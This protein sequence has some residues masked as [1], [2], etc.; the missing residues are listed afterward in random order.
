MF[1]RSFVSM[2]IVWFAAL[3]G[4]A[5]EAPTVLTLGDSITAGGSSFSCY[6]E[7]LVPA[8]E[9][10]GV[11]FIGP[12]RD[13]I[14]AHA[15]YGGRNSAFLRDKIGE[16][17]RAHPADFVL[18]H[19]G[20]NNF[21]ESN[22]VPRVVADTVSIVETI[23]DINPGAVILLGQVIPSG[24]LPK[25][26][27]IPELNRELA[28]LAARLKGRGDGIVVVDHADGFQWERD[29]VDDKVHP[30][31][32][33]AKKMAGKW[34]DALSPLLGSLTAPA[35]TLQHVAV[36][37]HLVTDLLMAKKGVRMTNWL[38]AE[39][40]SKFVMP[41][42]NRIW[43]PAKI[44]WTLGGVRSVSTRAENRAEVIDY[45]LKSKRDSDG[46]GDPQRIRKLWSILNLDHEAPREV[47]LYVIPYLGGTSQGNASPSQ[48]RVLMGQWTDKPSR[49]LRPPVKCLLVEKG[50]FRIG[51][52]SRTVAHE[53]GHILGLKHPKKNTPP[54]K[55][56]MGGSGYELT[57]EERTAAFG[58]AG[59]LF[60][61]KNSDD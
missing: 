48:R 2:V 36:R 61:G 51:S 52:F 19:A 38:T 32:L 33:G 28:T 15:G 58:K 3:S 41:E 47:N 37:F 27:Y 12:Q 50:D 46:A 8:L 20:H 5:G 9:K 23:R 35:E 13:T 30:N 57:G 31:T 54:F 22:P 4:H 6:R 39:M 60:V 40:I 44:E 49:G 10:R 29:T 7:F 24:K 42:V 26:S 55:R 11:R 25:Y 1:M 14:S 18:I 45:V 56:L 21:A 53:L 34:M 43:A 17:Y 59:A 16:I